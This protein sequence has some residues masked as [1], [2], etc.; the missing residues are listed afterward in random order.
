ME[1]SGAS[2][3]GARGGFSGAGRGGYSRP[4]VTSRNEEIRGGRFDNRTQQQQDR[5]R[6]PRNYEDA[7]SA[8]ARPSSKRMREAQPEIAHRPQS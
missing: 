5:T 1:G 3:R 2:F 4:E 8:E 7:Q 6:F